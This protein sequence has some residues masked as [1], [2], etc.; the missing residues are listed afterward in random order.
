MS[1][2]LL[3]VNVQP[4]II[5]VSGNL[6]TIP[7]PASLLPTASTWLA[8]DIMKGEI[9]WNSADDIYYYRDNSDAIQTLTEFK[10]LGELTEV[11][12]IAIDCKSIRN[13]IATIEDMA[14]V[15]TALT[16]SDL[17]LL[18]NLSMTKNNSDLDIVFT[19]AGTDLVFDVFDATNN[20]YTRATTLTISGNDANK[21]WELSFKK[22]GILDGTDNIIQV[23]G[24][25]DA[26]A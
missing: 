24:T 7:S 2:I 26:F 6:P 20:V 17:E 5:T 9:A 16:I 11:A 12:N 25:I 8:T 22:S 18:L 15:A 4:V 19:L 14:R 13:T 10:D 23:T 1:R 21:S 3:E